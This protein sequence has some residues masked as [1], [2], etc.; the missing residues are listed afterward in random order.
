M[1]EFEQIFLLGQRGNGIVGS[2][3]TI[4]W[5][6]IV[7]LA[8][9]GLWQ[10]FVKAGQPGWGAIIPIYN[11]I[12]LLEIA[13]RP[14]WWFLLM[15]IP[16]VNIVICIV[17]GIDIARNFGKGP[18]FGLGLTFLGFIFYPILGFGDARYRPT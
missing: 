8:I 9:A 12:L 1:N 7:V 15:F 5:L 17:V 3:F 11:I 10:T 13:E 2:F 18:G 14:I 16:I 4:I 6:A